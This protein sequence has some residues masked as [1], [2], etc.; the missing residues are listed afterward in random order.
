MAGISKKLTTFEKD[1]LLKI[2]NDQRKKYGLRPLKNLR[3]ETLINLTSDKN[4]NTTTS[5]ISD[6]G[7]EE[8]YQ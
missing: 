8:M 4:D 2:Q 7:Q 3:I 5:T 6:Y 1:V